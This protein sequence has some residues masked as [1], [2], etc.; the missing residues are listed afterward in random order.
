MSILSPGPSLADRVAFIAGG[1]LVK[2]AADAEVA[3]CLKGMLYLSQTGYVLLSVSNAFVRGIFANMHEP[4]VSLPLYPGTGGLNA[5]ITV[6]RPE[7][8][9]QLGGA[10]KI[11][12]RGKQFAYTIGRLKTMEPGDAWPGVER[13]WFCHVHSPE[14]QELRRSYGLD[15]FPNKG[16]NPFHIAV[17]VRKRGILARNEKSKADGS[18]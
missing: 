15:G 14:L 11:T 10:E 1:R 7:E 13:V 9:K 18:S 5:H 3:Y 6:F 2:C 12:E 16:Q 17:A 4:G 8:V